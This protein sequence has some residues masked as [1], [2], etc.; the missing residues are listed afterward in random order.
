MKKC[1]NCK[2][3]YSSD[4]CCFCGINNQLIEHPLIMGGKKCPCYEKYVKVKTK[5]EYPQ[6]KD[7]EKL[8]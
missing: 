7:K 4:I 3:L 1:I 2:Y 6:K 8:L 5:Y